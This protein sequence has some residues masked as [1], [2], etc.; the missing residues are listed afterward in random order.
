VVTI[1]EIDDN[2]FKDFNADEYGLIDPTNTVINVLYAEN[3]NDMSVY[4]VCLADTGTTS[5]IF[6]QHEVFTDYRPVDNI[7]ISGVGGTKTCAKGKGMIWMISEMNVHRQ[8]IKLCD[9]LHV[10]DSKHNLIS[11]GRWEA[12]GRSYHATDGLYCPSMAQ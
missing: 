8:L 12:D 9:T 3:E 4:I 5:H 10:S 1:E 11:L 7:T 6:H 2:C